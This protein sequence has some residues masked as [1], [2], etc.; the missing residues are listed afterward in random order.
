[1][2]KHPVTNQRRSFWAWLKRFSN[3]DRY[4]LYDGMILRHRGTF[5][6]DK[7][8]IDQIKSWQVELEQCFDYVV[9]GLNDATEVV[10]FDY[11]DDLLTI[12]RDRLPDRETIA[13]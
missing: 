4:E 6:P 12:L 10:W 7:L 2:H 11:Y 13:P 9:I 1:V 8:A 5:F 3:K